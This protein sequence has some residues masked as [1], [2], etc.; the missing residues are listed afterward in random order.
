MSGS[1]EEISNVLDVVNRTEYMRGYNACRRRVDEAIEEIKMHSDR[2][3]VGSVDGKPD[4]VCL[5]E[6]VLL[7]LKRYVEPPMAQEIGCWIPVDDATHEDYE[8]DK[9]GEI[10]STYTAN[11][12]PY[13]VY[14]YCPKCGAK[15]VE[16]QESEEI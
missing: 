5:L 7:S 4:D 8:C 2:W 13:E 9:C 6:D 14:R 10:V 15:M 3:Y 11:I 12:S 1:P 16:P